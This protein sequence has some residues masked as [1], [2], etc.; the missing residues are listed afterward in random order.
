M[1]LLIYSFIILFSSLSFAQSSN[2]DSLIDKIAFQYAGE[3]G[4]Y[5]IGI[6][7]KI[8]K[9]YSLSLHYGFVPPTWH[10]ETW[11]ILTRSWANPSRFVAHESGVTAQGVNLSAPSS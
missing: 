1:N 5:S 11:E 10:P 4:K 2:V 3:I 8:N 7:K 9:Y 6:G